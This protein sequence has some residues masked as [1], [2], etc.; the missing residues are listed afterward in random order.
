[1][2]P[3]RSPACT[4]TPAGDPTDDPTS[5]DPHDLPAD[6]GLPSVIDPDFVPF[7]LGGRILSVRRQEPARTIRDPGDAPAHRHAIDVDIQRRQKNTHLLPLSRRRRIW[8]SVTRVQYLAV[9][10]GNHRPGIG[11]R[12]TV[13]ISKEERKQPSEQRQR[14]RPGELLNGEQQ[15]GKHQCPRDERNTRAI[16][17]DHGNWS[18]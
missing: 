8:L 5:Q 10:R 12:V 16:D 7:V 14:E 13:R 6:D 11:R 9:S 15:S 4:S 2:I 17:L 1:M 18:R 3:K